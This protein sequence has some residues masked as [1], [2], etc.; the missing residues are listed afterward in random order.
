MRFLIYFAFK[1]DLYVYQGI[2]KLFE[3][4]NFNLWV[5]IATTLH[6]I[7]LKVNQSNL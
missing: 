2:V 6:D 4:I 1:G 5:T 3:K 7:Y